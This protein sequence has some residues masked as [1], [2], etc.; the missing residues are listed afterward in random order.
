MCEY[1]GISINFRVDRSFSPPAF[2]VFA[3]KPCVITSSLA[4]IPT[5]SFSVETPNE[6][7][8]VLDNPNTC[9]VFMEGPATVLPGMQVNLIVHAVSKEEKLTILK[10][11]SFAERNTQ[12]Q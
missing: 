1:P 7:Q 12:R 4:Y 10:V 6:M 2:V 11:I 3:D 8:F 5:Q 9:G